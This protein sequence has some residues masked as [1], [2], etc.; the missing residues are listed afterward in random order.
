MLNV[1]NRHYNLKE[2]QTL[3]VPVIKG[4][5]IYEQELLNRLSQTAQSMLEFPKEKKEMLLCHDLEGIKNILFIGLGKPGKLSINDLRGVA[6]RAVKK[7]IKLKLSSI[8]IA[9]PVNLSFDYLQVFDAFCEGAALRNYLFDRYK[10]EKKDTLLDEVALF[11]HW[12]LTEPL[13]GVASRALT[14]ALGTMMARDWVTTPAND[15]T[16][17]IFSQQLDQAIQGMP[18]KAEIMEESQLA[19]LGFGAMLAVAQGSANK[20]RFVVLDYD[21]ADKQRTIALIGKAVCFDSG[22]LNLKPDSAINDMKTDMSGGAAV[23][24]AV[25]TAARL[26]LPT[27]IIAAIPMVENMPSGSAIRPGDIVKSYSGKTIEILNTDAEGRLILVDALCYIKDKYN[28][29]VM[30][31]LATLTGACVVALGEKIAGLFTPADEL[32]SRLLASADRTYERCWRLPLPDDYR[33]MIKSELADYKNISQKRWGGAI[34]AALFLHEF[35]DFQQW[36]HIDI[37]GPAH[38]SKEE[39]YCPAGGTGFGVRLL[40]DYLTRL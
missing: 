40:I 18:I 39:S 28:P 31:D 20:P 15:M 19:S 38:I 10:K 32:A 26:G 33:E 6:G 25:I 4:M 11:T 3:V 7:A 16:P 27:R 37:A 36:A 9:V 29:D 17:A 24:A 21:P 13:A 2:V 14:V 5:D 22:G 35:V 1:L 8:T 34:T 12:D 30:I 23:A